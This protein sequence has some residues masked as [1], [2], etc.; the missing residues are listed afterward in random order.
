MSREHIANELIRDVFSL[1]S[2][3]SWRGSNTSLRSLISLDQFCALDLK[4]ALREF[5]LKNHIPE[6]HINFGPFGCFAE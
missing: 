4:I 1:P 2:L 5:R 6:L 3:G